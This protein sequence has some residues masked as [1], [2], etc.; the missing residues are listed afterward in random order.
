MGVSENEVDN[1]LHNADKEDKDDGSEEL[2]HISANRSRL[3]RQIFQELL[4]FGD[5]CKCECV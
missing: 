4:S 5:Q 3:E 2:T 1:H